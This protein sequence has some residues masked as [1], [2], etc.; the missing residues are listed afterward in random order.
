M[1]KNNDSML[2]LLGGLVLGSAIGGIIALLTA[3]MKGEELRKTIADDAEKYLEQVKEKFH[4]DLSRTKGVTE[5]LVEKAEK[6]VS[7][8]KK[9]G[10]ADVENTSEVEAEINK[11]KAS[12][13]EANA[14]YTQV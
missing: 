10:K 3:P 9:L 5:S 6:I 7:L 12:L 11:L 14:S 8:S 2:P 13:D 4:K 1:K